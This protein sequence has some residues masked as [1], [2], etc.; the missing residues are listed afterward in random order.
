MAS[1]RAPPA[2]ALG[3]LHG[4]HGANASWA[5][6]VSRVSQDTQISST[7]WTVSLSATTQARRESCATRKT[8]GWTHQSSGPL[9]PRPPS[10]TGE[11]AWQ[12]YLGEVPGEG[13]CRSGCSLS[14]TLW[15]TGRKRGHLLTCI[16]FPLL[17]DATRRKLR[18]AICRSM[19]MNIQ[20]RRPPPATVPRN[21]T[22]HSFDGMYI[23]TSPP[24]LFQSTTVCCACS[25]S[26]Y[27]AVR[28][29]QLSTQDESH[30]ALELAPDLRVLVTSAR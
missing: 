16:S 30:Q 18:Y 9:C 7:E 20:L 24:L 19:N 17:R 8:D 13:P 22:S 21:Y 11:I 2:P 12:W 1:P 14:E 6:D 27:S 29:I 5:S 28:Y 4:K 15:A 10:P 3:M 25:S 23:H 26:R